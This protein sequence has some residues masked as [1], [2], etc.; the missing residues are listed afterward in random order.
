MS[1]KD[2][3]TCAFAI[4]LTIAVLL[5]GVLYSVFAISI[6]SGR[7]AQLLSFESRMQDKAAAIAKDPHASNVDALQSELATL[8][9]DR[10]SLRGQIYYGKSEDWGLGFVHCILPLDGRCFHR[11]ASETNN[12][13]LAM[14]SGAL[15]ACLSLLLGFRAQATSDQPAPRISGNVVSVVCLIPLGLIV[16]LLT[17]YLLRGTKGA[18]LTP[19]SEVVQIENPY[20]IA[21]ACTM[22]AFFSDRILSWLSTLVDR[23]PIKKSP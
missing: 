1:G 13:Y 11:N 7:I 14:A 10:D 15:G 8:T 4:S 5:V 23:L 16:G 18:L 22:A 9:G 3:V 6:N 19:L 2:S 21:F 17:L 20:G 12:L